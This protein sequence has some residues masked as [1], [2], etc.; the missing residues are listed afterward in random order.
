MPHADFSRD[1]LQRC[2]EAALVLPLGNVDWSDWGRP[3]RVTE[4]LHRLGK[5]PAFATPDALPMPGGV[6]VEAVLGQP[7]VASDMHP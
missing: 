5:R 4:S 2:P 1:L 7:R 6:P 3:E